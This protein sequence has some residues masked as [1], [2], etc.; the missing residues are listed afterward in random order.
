MR[1]DLNDLEK[2][3]DSEKNVPDVSQLWKKTNCRKMGKI[4]RKR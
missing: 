4:H 1:L 2:N 3:D